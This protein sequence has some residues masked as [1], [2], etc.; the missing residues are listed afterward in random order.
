[1]SNTD[2]EPLEFHTLTYTLAD[3]KGAIAA[4]GPLAGEHSDHVFAEAER[5]RPGGAIHVEFSWNRPGNA[6]HGG[7]PHTSIA[8]FKISGSKLTVETNSVNRAKGVR[9][10]I[11]RRL[12]GAATFVRD[13]RQSLDDALTDAEIRPESKRDRLARKRDDELQALPEVQATIAEMT[14]KHYDTWPDAPLPALN[15]KTPRASVKTKEG[16]ERV[17]ALLASF[18]WRQGGQSPALTYDFN[19]LRAMLGLPLR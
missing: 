19:R 10:E 7:M 9:E 4:L 8:R 5:K 16:R 11:E 14:A 13:E 15:G 1:M 18:E 12:G 17:E 3:A 6:K 2:D